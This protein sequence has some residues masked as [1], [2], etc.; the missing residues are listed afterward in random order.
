MYDWMISLPEESHDYVIRSSFLVIDESF[1]QDRSVTIIYSGPI[2][3]DAEGKIDK[4]GENPG[5]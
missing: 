1:V 5:D 4:Y 2:W 3:V